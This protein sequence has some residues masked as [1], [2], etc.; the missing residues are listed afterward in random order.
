MLTDART[1]VEQG[2][3]WL[4]RHTEDT[5]DI[6]ALVERYRPAAELL[7]AALPRLLDGE[8]HAELQRRTYSLLGEDV[9]DALAE[10]VAVMPFLPP[11]FEIAEVSETT[12]HALEVVTDASFKVAAALRGRS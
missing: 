12:G 10:R 1:L 4:L 5:I 9:P 6:Q 2:T 3:R 11:A 7:G 8:D